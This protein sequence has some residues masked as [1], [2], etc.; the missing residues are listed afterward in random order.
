MNLRICI[1]KFLDDARAAGVGTTLRTSQRTLIAEPL[2]LVYEA[3]K[4]R[5]VSSDLLSFSFLSL[6]FVFVCRSQGPLK[7]YDGFFFFLD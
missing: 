5:I 6:A 1:Y 4:N 7:K 3:L 2:P